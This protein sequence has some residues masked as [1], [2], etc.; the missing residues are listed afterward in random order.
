MT[1][2]SQEEQTTM[3]RWLRNSFLYKIH[4]TLVPQQNTHTQRASEERE[5]DYQWLINEYQ[6]NYD[7]LIKPD[8][9]EE[10]TTTYKELNDAYNR[11]LRS[12]SGL[13]SE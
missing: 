6:Y 4:S 9:A 5:R 11:Q 1:R 8:R 2:S 12:S 7:Y 10:P 13:E 3:R